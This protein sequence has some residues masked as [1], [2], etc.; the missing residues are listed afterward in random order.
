MDYM[1]RALHLARRAVEASSPNPPVGAVVV[2]DGEIIGKGFTLPPGEGHAEAVAL[3]K[4]GKGARGAVLYTTLEPCAHHGRVPPCSQAIIRAGIAEVHMAMIDPNPLV[5]GKGKAE[6]EAAGIQCVLGER[7]EEA[8]RLIEAYV[9]HITTGMPFVTA[10]FAMSLDGKIATRTGHSQWITGE[11]ARRHARGLRRSHDAVMVG[12]NT[13]LS[14]DPSLTARDRWDKPY[15][16]QPL[17]VVVDSHGRTP[18]TA[19]M[20][21]Q[22]GRTVIAT[23]GAG[24]DAMASLEKAGAEMLV[25]PGRE[26]WVNLRTL[27]G[28]LGKQEI[29]SVLVEGGGDLLGSLFDLKLV[30]KVVAFVAPTVIGGRDA[31]SPVAGAGARGME[32]ALRL[33][34]AHTRRLG[35]DILITGYVQ[36][37]GTEC[38][39]ES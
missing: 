30:D 25:L 7:E 21:R 4:A 2:K 3:E 1:Q 12:I 26:G 28:L 11:R 23:S 36:L 24:V 27:L 32:E 33:R 17:R 9:K 10:K 5:N 6:L 13:V 38:S 14:D 22:P 37:G 35:E 31:P 8:C 16:R 20:L 39:A 29:T 19:R 18:P 34:E 15:E